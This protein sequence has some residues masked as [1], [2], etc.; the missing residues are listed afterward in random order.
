MESISAFLSTLS[1]RARLV[2]AMTMACTFALILTTFAYFSHY[3]KYEKYDS[4]F[5]TAEVREA[6]DQHG[7]MLV[8]ARKGTPRHIMSAELKDGKISVCE[9]FNNGGGCIA[10]EEIIFQRDLISLL[11]Q[12]GKKFTQRQWDFAAQTLLQNFRK[13]INE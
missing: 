11:N 1:L 13:S 8:I 2:L 10:E 12:E 5:W 9:E 7:K 3:Y 4:K 6:T